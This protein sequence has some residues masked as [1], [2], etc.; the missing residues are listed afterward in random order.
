MGPPQPKTAVDTQ[1]PLQQLPGCLQRSLCFRGTSPP[2]QPG[3]SGGGFSL[4]RCP[5]SEREDN[6]ISMFYSSKHWPNCPAS[7]HPFLV[8]LEPEPNLTIVEALA[9]GPL[10]GAG[11]GVKSRTEVWAPT[12]NTKG[13]WLQ[14]PLKQRMY[15]HHGIP[16]TGPECDRFP[17][18]IRVTTFEMSDG[19]KK[20]N[21]RN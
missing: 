11:P 16:S 5:A 1:L 12:W 13:C 9:L 18:D 3:L 10:P 17:I 7:H 8:T 6:S 19:R 4:L 14:A 2:L 20:N 15:F 21:Y